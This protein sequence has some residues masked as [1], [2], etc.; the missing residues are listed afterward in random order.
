MRLTHQL[1]SVR[2]D[3]R[4]RCKVASAKRAHPM[5]S[6]K[7]IQRDASK[8]E[9]APTTRKDTLKDML[10]EVTPAQIPDDN[11]GLIARLY[12]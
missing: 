4:L 5:L 6:K 7:Y 2:T 1:M 10:N 3:L 12:S 8:S 11:E 9:A